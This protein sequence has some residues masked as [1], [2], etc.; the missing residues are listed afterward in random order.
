MENNLDF[1]DQDDDP[2]GLLIELDNETGNNQIKI[3]W[4]NFLHD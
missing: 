2:T 4:N 3:V 1:L